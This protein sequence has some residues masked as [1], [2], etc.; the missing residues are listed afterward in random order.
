MARRARERFGIGLRPIYLHMLRVI[1]Q[2]REIPAL[3]DAVIMGEL[4]I[5]KARRICGVITK[6]NAQ[7]WIT[8]AMTLKKNLK[9]C[10]NQAPPPPNQRRHPADCTESQ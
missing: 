8:A 10:R 3:R 4:S 1:R 7:E 9:D 2:E 6:D 5:S